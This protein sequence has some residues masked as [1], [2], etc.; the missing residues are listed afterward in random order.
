MSTYG[1]RTVLFI[2]VLAAMILAFSGGAAAQDTS[3]TDTN[4][5]TELEITVNDSQNGEA[6]TTVPLTVEDAASDDLPAELDATTVNAVVADAGVDDYTQL[7]TTDILDAYSSYLQGDTIGGSQQITAL[8]LLDFHQYALLHPDEFEDFD[9]TAAGQPSFSVADQTVSPEGGQVSIDHDGADAYLQIHHE[10]LSAGWSVERP[11]SATGNSDETAWTGS[12]P[13]PA[14]ITLVPDGDASTGETVELTVII[15][16]ES[17]QETF[18][19]TIEDTTSG[20]V[21]AA[22]DATTVNA[23]VAETDGASDYTQLETLDILDAYGSY[24]ED[25]TV[26]NTELDSSIPILDLYAYAIKN[27]GEFQ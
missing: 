1:K 9:E 25:N 22:L 6:T 5:T 18:N 3:P 19:V 23:V 21:P 13:N 10:T 26:G 4:I 8:H 14:T 16:D 20:D 24:L 2:T 11:A 27:P 7:S 15:D 17:N 12:V